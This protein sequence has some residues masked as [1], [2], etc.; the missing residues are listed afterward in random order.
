MVSPCRELACCNA[1]WPRPLWCSTALRRN[2]KIPNHSFGALTEMRAACCGLYTVPN[3][4]HR[5]NARAEL[6]VLNSTRRSPTKA[7]VSATEV[8]RDPCRFGLAVIFLEVVCQI[9]AQ[10]ARHRWASKVPGAGASPHSHAD[11]RVVFAVARLLDL[12]VDV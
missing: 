5:S 3:T 9:Q 4:L 7:I 1:A 2:F 11:F 6:K 12:R 8:E 10:V